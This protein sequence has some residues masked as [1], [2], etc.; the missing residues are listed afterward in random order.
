MDADEIDA[1]A[2][3]V[4]ALVLALDE[5]RSRHAAGLEAEPAIGRLFQEHH[6]AAH[7]DTAA[8]L[9]E[10]GREDLA[11]RVA[12]LRAE[13]AAAEHEERW[14]A[15]DARAADVR[16]SRAE[17]LGAIEI[18]L[19][20]EEDP[21][22]RAALSRAAAEAMAEAA[23]A[24]EAWAE[25][26]ARARAEVGLAPDWTAVVEGDAALSASDDAYRDVLA[27]SAR[28][29]L[30]E[31]KR[32]AGL[33]RGDL[34][35]VLALR[36]WDG[37]FKAGMLEVSLRA[38]LEGLGL[39]LA[40]IEIDR[41]YGPGAWP[42]AHAVGAHASFRPRGGAGDWQDLIAAFARAFAAAAA[43]PSSRDP[44]LAEAL[45]WLLGSLLLEP[46]WLAERADVE[47][48]HAPDVVRDLALRRLF[49]LRADAAALRV[50]TEVERGLSGAAW[51]NAHRDALTQATLA[52]WD[53]V[54]ASRDGDASR[55]AAAVRGAGAGERLR[56]EVRERFDEDWWRNPRTAAHLAELLAAQPLPIPEA[57]P[58][59][60]G[61]ARMLLSRLEG[62]RG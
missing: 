46:R 28:R 16:G 21:E 4:D 47:K 22:R 51:R 43:R 38:S 19:P 62:G 12:S 39:D 52:A 35:R 24:R 9:R 57:P 30:G 6:R 34:L 54:R 40:R 37:L 36:R 42:G 29:E 53:G 26:R 15:A 25:A 3:D 1:L 14:R 11:G 33:A 44:V 23:S 48:R 17:P 45:A 41:G 5:T 49:A 27:F 31:P 8:A 59:A 58:P 2:G 61:A 13:R 60:A 20:R 56:I 55:L 7:K 50:A 10:D 18:A 32:G